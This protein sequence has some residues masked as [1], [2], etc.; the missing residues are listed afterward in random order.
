MGWREERGE[1][2]KNG[3]KKGGKKEG[4]RE[5]DFILFGCVLLVQLP[6]LLVFHRDLL[7]HKARRERKENLEEEGHQG[8][9]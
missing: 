1:G 7:V 2:G 6:V 5:G 3:G 8:K 9:M 4:G